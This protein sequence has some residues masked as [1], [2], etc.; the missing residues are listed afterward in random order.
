MGSGQIYSSAFWRRS[1]VQG[2]S[3]ASNDIRQRVVLVHEPI[4]IQVIL[5]NDKLDIDV[6]S[7]A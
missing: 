1:V 7:S 2:E 3:A 4:K 5:A 6:G